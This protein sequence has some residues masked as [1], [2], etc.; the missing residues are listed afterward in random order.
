M[1]IDVFAPC[2]CHA[3]RF[4]TCQAPVYH[5]AFGREIRELVEADHVGYNPVTQELRV[6]GVVID[7]DLWL[8]A[9]VVPPLELNR[10][11]V[12]IHTGQHAAST[13]S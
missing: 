9:S 13:S 12:V 8:Y 11:T 4:E 2:G 1:R 7:D 3:A 5:G 10:Y 6:G